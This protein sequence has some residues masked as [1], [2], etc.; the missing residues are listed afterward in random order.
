M[1]IQQTQ[2][3][4][5]LHP[6]KLMMWMAMG[7]MFM[8]FAG[9]TSAFI[10]QSG[11]ASWTIFKLPKAFYVSTILILIS[12]Y[13]MNKA[14]KAYKEKDRKAYKQA[15]IFTSILGLLFIASQIWGFQDLYR[16]RITL[17]NAVSN[18]FLYI[19]SGLHIAHMVGAIIALVIVYLMGLRKQVKVYSS[20]GIE[21]MS[22]SGIL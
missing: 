4:G 20:V 9:L 15:I 6:Q 22:C 11:N 5:R 19:I 1:S 8:V 18:G 17:Q 10:L 2:Q 21:V 16:Q 14:V 13:T 12:S 7:S 3:R